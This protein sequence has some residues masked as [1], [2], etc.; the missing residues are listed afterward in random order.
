MWLPDFKHPQFHQ[1]V[2]NR[3]VVYT[4]KKFL[5]VVHCHCH[6]RVAV[7]NRRPAISLKRGKIGPML[8]LMT[9]S[10]LHTRFRLVPKLM[11]LDDLERPFC[12]LFQNTCVFGIG[13]HHENFN[14][15]KPILPGRRCSAM[16]LVSDYKVYADIREGSLEARHKTTVG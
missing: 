5:N 8:L 2:L 14:E 6:C 10:K 4:L 11:T 3:R 12:I 9:N 15:D 16:T 13:T 7:L 1:C